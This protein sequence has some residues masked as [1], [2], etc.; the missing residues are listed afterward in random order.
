M[1]IILSYRR[2]DSAGIAGRILDRFVAHFGADS[3]FMDID[4]IPFGVDFR[5]HIKSE[6]GNSDIVLVIMGLRWFSDGGVRRIDNENDFVRIEVETALRRGIP[7]IPVLVDGATMPLL[8]D[9]PHSL[10]DLVFRNA[11]VVDPGRDF[12]MHVDRLIKS[13]IRSVETSRLRE[14]AIEQPAATPSDAVAVEKSLADPL[15]SGSEVTFAA[16]SHSE[17]LE[18]PSSQLR[19][20]GVQNEQNGPRFVDPLIASPSARQLPVWTV[21]F[22]YCCLI[23]TLFFAYRY[24]LTRHANHVASEMEAVFSESKIEILRAI[25]PPPPPLPPPEMLRKNP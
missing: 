6:L 24:V 25:I 17:N 9:L 20:A 13:I 12:N 11:A 7:V 3:V 16:A 18:T 21:A 5:E 23:I 22:S 14:R 8:E 1:K 4:N 15:R 2:A 10:H 19:D